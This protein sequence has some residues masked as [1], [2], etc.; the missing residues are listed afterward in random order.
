MPLTGQGKP[1]NCANGSWFNHQTKCIITIY[2]KLLRAAIGNKVC[3]IPTQGTIHMILMMKQSHRQNHINIR[4][5]RNKNPSIIFIN[6][7]Y[8]S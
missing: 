6:T 1:K 4:L 7:L 5:F 2:P 8:S 3:L